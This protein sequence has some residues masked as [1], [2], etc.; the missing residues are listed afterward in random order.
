MLAARDRRDL[1]T[2]HSRRV[3]CIQVR[4]GSDVLQLWVLQLTHQDRHK[5]GNHNIKE[6]SSKLPMAGCLQGIWAPSTPLT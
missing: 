6:S 4:D 3:L 2:Q 1:G 5:Q